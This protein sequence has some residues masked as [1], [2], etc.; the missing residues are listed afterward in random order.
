MDVPAAV[1]MAIHPRLSPP[2]E[3]ELLALFMGTFVSTAPLLLTS[4]RPT[5]CAMCPAP[6]ASNMPPSATAPFASKPCMVNAY[7]PFS[8]DSCP[9][10][11]VMA[12]VELL[13]VMLRSCTAHC[14]PALLESVACTVILLV[15]LRP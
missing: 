11:Q 12:G 7:C 6:S 14:A 9:D 8:R 5:A 3:Y 10:P 13:I 1:V 2:T 4:S 15:P